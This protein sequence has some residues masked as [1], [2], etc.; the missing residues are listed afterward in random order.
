MQPSG[1][2]LQLTRLLER[3]KGYEYVNRLPG[4]QTHTPNT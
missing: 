3:V 2:E 4:D 1:T